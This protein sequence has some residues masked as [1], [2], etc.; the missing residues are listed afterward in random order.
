MR[1]RIALGIVVAA[2]LAAAMVG[3]GTSLASSGS[4]GVEGT[5]RVTIHREAPPPG[6]PADIEALINYAADG[7]A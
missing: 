2:L 6:Q 7:W 5:W 3:G 4:N 1:T